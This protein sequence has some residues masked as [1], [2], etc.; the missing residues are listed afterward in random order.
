MDV[1]N[2][3]EQRVDEYRLLAFVEGFNVAKESRKEE[4]WV[5]VWPHLV[6]KELVV[7]LFVTFILIVISLLF[8]APLE[9]LAN[10]TDT[11][12]PA[13]APWYFLGLQELLVYFDP[14]IAGVLLPGIIVIGLMALPYLDH[15]QVVS[16]VFSY[17]NRQFAVTVFCLGL[18]MWFA[19][20]VIGTYFRGPGW[21]WYWPWEDQSIHKMTLQGPKNLPPLLGS[22]L[23]ILY[24]GL[25]LLLPAW[26]NKDFFKDRGPVRYILQV[27][28]LL[29]ML[30]VLG[31]VFLRWVFHIK[32]ILAL[33]WFNI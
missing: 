13:K 18:V 24:V 31:K 30:G 20:I 3:S 9:E 27:V 26:L 21:E 33:P 25:G 11:P 12:N 8:N 4:R 2:V 1:R 28:L 14:W 17:S 19:L 23:V 5:S 7:M 10:P 16:G 15:R 32:Y 22:V 29:M 6:F